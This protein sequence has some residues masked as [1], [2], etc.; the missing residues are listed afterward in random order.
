[1]TKRY[2]LGF[3]FSTT[4]DTVMLKLKQRP[5]WQK[6]HWNGVG[7]HIEQL[8]SPMQCIAREF[9]EETKCALDVAP[10]EWQ[11]VCM[12]SGEG[13]E[14][15]VFYAMHE[16]IY[17]FLPVDNEVLGWFRVDQIP[18]NIIP[19]VAWM[20]PMCLSLGRGERAAGFRIH[21]MERWV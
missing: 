3:L 10:P 1:M 9:N 6:N 5:E 13:W 19:N 12:I 20:V 2:T 7:G 8:E 14:M 17:A 16:R 4:G 15:F 21:E 18:P 11:P